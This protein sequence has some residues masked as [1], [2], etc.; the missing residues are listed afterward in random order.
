MSRYFMPAL[1][2]AATGWV[3]WY[4]D[5]HE[6]SKIFIPMVDVLFPAAADDPDQL[7][8]HSVQVLFFVSVAVLVI[9]AVEHA[10]ALRRRP[11]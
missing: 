8:D 4:N 3:S 9:T 11:S 2:F 6:T 1:F 7:G 10:I 5:S